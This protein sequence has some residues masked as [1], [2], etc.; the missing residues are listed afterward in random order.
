M[1]A[2]TRNDA[3]KEQAGDIPLPEEDV[4][5]EEAEEIPPLRLEGLVLHPRQPEAD[6]QDVQGEGEEPGDHEDNSPDV[7]PGGGSKQKCRQ[8]QPPCPAA[9]FPAGHSISTAPRRQHKD[10]TRWRSIS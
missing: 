7:K 4:V 5:E 6:D 1:P 2:A 9:T 10:A 8:E 3:K